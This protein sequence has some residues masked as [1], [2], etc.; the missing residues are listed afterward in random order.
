MLPPN[1]FPLLFRSFVQSSHLRTH[2]RTSQCDR[3]TCHCSNMD[4]TCN[5]QCFL[6]KIQNTRINVWMH[7]QNESCEYDTNLRTIRQ[8]IP[9][10]ICTWIYYQ[11]LCI[12]PF[13]LDYMDPISIRRFPLFIQ[14]MQISNVN[15]FYQFD[16]NEERM[17]ACIPS[18]CR[19]TKPGLHL[20]KYPSSSSIHV[21]PFWHGSLLQSSDMCWQFLPSK[22]GWQ[23]PVIAQN[24]SN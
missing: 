23:L 13:Q 5:R 6:K 21:A 20:H 12:L 3:C 11:N 9:F 7:L 15:F 2:I 22:P 4:C 24:L 8:N 16:L 10:G 1:T 18:H 14:C 17:N 19:P